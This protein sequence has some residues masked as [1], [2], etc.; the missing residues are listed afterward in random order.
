MTDIL[1]WVCDQYRKKLWEVDPRSC[2]QVDIRMINAGQSWVCDQ[3]IVDPDELVTARQ[4]QE[5]HGIGEKYVRQLAIRYGV[6]VRGKDGK[7]NLYRLGD[8]LSA[9]AAKKCSN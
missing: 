9:Q 7:Y 4:I 6:K 1:R 5:R 2:Q 8:V 3:T